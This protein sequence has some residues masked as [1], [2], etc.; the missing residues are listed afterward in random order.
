MSDSYFR[1]LGLTDQQIEAVKCKKG[2]TMI[3]AGA[4]SGKTLVIAHRFI[5]LHK[6]FG[7][8]P[9][10]I[11]C[12]TFTNK[13]VK[14]MKDRIMACV[15]YNDYHRFQGNVHVMTFHALCKEILLSINSR[16]KGSNIK[17][18]AHIA[19]CMPIIKEILQDY[20]HIR[21]SYAV[22]VLLDK[23]RWLCKSKG[24]DFKEDDLVS[25]GVR[26]T[27][28]ADEKQ[29]LKKFP[30]AD[31]RAIYQRFDDELERRQ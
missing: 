11:L 19:K 10:R 27:A 8:D 25:I 17:R 23:L 18:F 26:Y 21:A 2:P 28:I 1:G 15:P 13:A 31:M 29:L 3:V 5:Y 7:L 14:N 4:G 24:R 22:S 6:H 9:E 30:Y 20:P 16:R 12:V